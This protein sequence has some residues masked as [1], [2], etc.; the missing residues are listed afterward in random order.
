[1]KSSERQ[2]LRVDLP[3]SAEPLGVLVDR[4]PVALEKADLK[5]R[6]L[7]TSYFIN[8]ART[9]SSD[10]PFS[11]TILF[12]MAVKPD[13][14]QTAGGSLLLRLPIIGGYEAKG[15]AI[16]QLRLG[17]WI[18]DEYALIGTPENFTSD[19]RTTLRDL[20]RKRRSTYQGTQD[21]DTWIGTDAG[22]VFE[23]PVEGHRHLYS[24]LAGRDAVQ[25][26]GWWHLP[27]YTWIVSGAIIAIAFLLRNTSW[28]NKLTLLI[29]AA[30]GACTYALK[31]ADLVIHGLAVSVYGLTALVA[32][33]VVH[34]LLSRRPPDVAATPTPIPVVPISSPPTSPSPPAD[35]GPTNSDEV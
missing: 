13:A 19:T 5:A 33:W 6:D 35:P 24:S 20:F 8:V 29:L 28:E 9:K 17:V 21:L 22:G 16:Q 30:F 1:M 11:L 32:I 26:F 3:T 23:F 10:E 4:K 12:R 14:F 7:W 31:D 27:Y 25:G 2:R 15:V 18:P 34:A